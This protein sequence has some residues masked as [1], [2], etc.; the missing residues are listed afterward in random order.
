MKTKSS[1]P[2]R[3]EGLFQTHLRA[4]G[5]IV[6]EIPV[7]ETEIFK[8]SLVDDVLKLDGNFSVLRTEGIK[9]TVEKTTK[10]LIGS[11]FSGEGLLQVFRGTGEVWLMPTKVVYEEMINQALPFGVGGL[12]NPIVEQQLENPENRKK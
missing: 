12:D 5:I 4:T 9:F 11:G 6:L 10:T 1:A 7:P 8:Y 2:F 3:T